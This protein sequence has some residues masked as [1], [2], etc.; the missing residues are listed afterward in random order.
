MKVLLTSLLA[1]VALTSASTVKLGTHL[2]S[3]SVIGGI[4]STPGGAPF[5]VSLQNIGG[6][7]VLDQLSLEIGLLLQHIA[8]FTQ[9]LITHII[10]HPNFAG[11]A[12]PNDIGLIYIEQP[13]Y[14]NLP[15][16][17]A[18]PVAQITLANASFVLSGNGT[19]YGW[20]TMQSGYMADTLQK[21]DTSVLD[22]N[23]CKAYLPALAPLTPV[24]I[25]CFGNGTGIYEG[26]CNGD[27]GGPLVQT[28]SAGPVLI[29]VVSWG[30]VPCETSPYP[31]VYTATSVYKDWIDNITASFNP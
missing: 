12:G 31:S 1:M 18:A 23:D 3:P 14:F 11:G 5:I 15:L 19:V 10:P 8:W 22:Y 24:N 28:V 2:A 4:N 26:A 20:G 13:F 27:S 7:I 6:I 30:Y 29:G 16:T 25:C 9:A 21:L 17:V